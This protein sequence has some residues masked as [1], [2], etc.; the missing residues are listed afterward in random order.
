M[1]HKNVVNMFAEDLFMLLLSVFKTYN[2]EFSFPEWTDV[3][4]FA[5]TKDI[6]CYINMVSTICEPLVPCCDCFVC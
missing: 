1:K 4:I 2:M 3:C 6:Y 5:Y